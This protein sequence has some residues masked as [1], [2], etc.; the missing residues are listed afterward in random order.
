M[1]VTW[2]FCINI[3]RKTAKHLLVTVW[4]FA[5]FI[6]FKKVLYCEADGND[7]SVFCGLFTKTR[8]LFLEKMLLSIYFNI[9]F[10][11]TK[12]WIPFHCVKVN[13]NLKTYWKSRLQVIIQTKHNTFPVIMQ[14]EWSV[15]SWPAPAAHWAPPQPDCVS[16]SGPGFG[17]RGSVPP[18]PRLSSARPPPAHASPWQSHKYITTW[19]IQKAAQPGG[20]P[21]KHPLL[22]RWHWYLL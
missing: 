11:I 21:G 2:S 10:H 13:K 8:T 5:D 7:Q 22:C 20:L 6:K 4:R 15:P 12:N 19:H 17:P 3:F 1:T 18:P 9:I 16:V 14:F